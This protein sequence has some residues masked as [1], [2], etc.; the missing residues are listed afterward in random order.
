[1]SHSASAA[2][3]FLQAMPKA[4]LHLHLDG[5]LRPVTALELASTRGIAAPTSYQGMFDVLV[6]AAHPGSQAELLKSFELPISLM[7]DVEAL[8][9]ITTELVEDKAADRV[10]YMEIKWAPALHVQRGLTLDEVIDAV[11]AAAHA[12][13]GRSNVVVTLTAVALRSDDP[14]LNVRVADAAVRHRHRGVTGFDLAGF[15]EAF[16]DP[17]LH[18]AA[19]DV[20]RAGG[21][22]ITV[23]AGELLDNGSLVRRALELQP[24]RIAHGASAIGDPAVIEEL[25]ARGV[26]LDLCPTSNVQAGTVASIAE[27]PLAALLRRGVGVT[28]NTDDTTISNITLSEEM[29]SCHDELGL[30]LGEI[31]ACT[32]HALG[33]AFVDEETRGELLESFRAWASGIPELVPG[34][35]AAG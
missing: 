8:Q 21:L 25:I 31:W 9:R 19:F 27:H 24:R 4:E 17:L 29:A 30:T 10:R 3:R 33:V 18:F 28:I 14:E 13:A 32:L 7:Q 6:A 34:Y 22:G 35:S 16:P 1:M 23:H 2:F 12:A 5:C 15:E 11:A 20:A 26:T